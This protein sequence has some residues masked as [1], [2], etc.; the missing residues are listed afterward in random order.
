[1][2]LCPLP[3]LPSPL[4]KLREENKGKT[5]RERG[6]TERRGRTNALDFNKELSQQIAWPYINHAEALGN[7]PKGPENSSAP[8]WPP[9]VSKSQNK[10]FFLSFKNKGLTTL[11]AEPVHHNHDP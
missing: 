9:Q 7:M 1:M 6:A 2:N 3:V 5:E 11:C 4:L 8:L 10:T